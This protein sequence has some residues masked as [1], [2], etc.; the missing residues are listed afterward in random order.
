MNKQ[1]IIP[2]QMKSLSSK[3]AQILKLLGID[4]SEL[5]PASHQKDILLWSID[6]P[7]RAHNVLRAVLDYNKGGSDWRNSMKLSEFVK[8]F[9]E[10]ELLRYRNC[11]RKTL[12]EINETIY[13]YGFSLTKGY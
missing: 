13:P 2:E 4:I 3:D 6:F 11:G 8:E 10:R 7:I 9:S 1:Y 5:V 12:R